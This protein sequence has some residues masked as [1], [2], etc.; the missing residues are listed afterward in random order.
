MRLVP[1][2]LHQHNIME[3]YKKIA[4]N[5]FLQIFDN[6]ML[7]VCACDCFLVNVHPLFYLILGQSTWFASLSVSINKMLFSH[8]RWCNINRKISIWVQ[9]KIHVIPLSSKIEPFRNIFQI[10]FSSFD[11]LTLAIF[12][13][14]LN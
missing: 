14:E 13:N 11:V 6:S 2:W 5:R 7:K 1:N 8:K 10:L 12:N 4:C 9:N 3:N